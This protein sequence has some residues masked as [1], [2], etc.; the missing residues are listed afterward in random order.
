M[1]RKIDWDEQ[2]RCRDDENS[3]DQESDDEEPRIKDVLS[4]L[5]DAVPRQKAS[6]LSHSMAAS[7]DILF[8]SPQGELLTNERIIP[9][10]NISELGEYV[11][12]PHIIMT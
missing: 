8:C 11:L 4:D 10:T 1:K 6:D 2:E 12:L 7:K 5:F 3:S 9:A